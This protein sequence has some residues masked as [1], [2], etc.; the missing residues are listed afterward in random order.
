MI[1]LQL[2]KEIE[3]FTTPLFSSGLH[4]LWE[5]STKSGLTDYILKPTW[6]DQFLD[7]LKQ[8]MWLAITNKKQSKEDAQ[9]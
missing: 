5:G 7:K 9:I 3:K 1:F 4:A 2:V 8:I 6:F